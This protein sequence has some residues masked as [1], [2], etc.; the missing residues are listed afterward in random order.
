MGERNPRRSSPE[1][2]ASQNFAPPHFAAKHQ[3]EDPVGPPLPP[4]TQPLEGNS[5]GLQQALPQHPPFAGLPPGLAIAGVIQSSS[6]AGPMPRPDD[7]AAYER[8]VTGLARQIA[9][10][11]ISEQNLRGGLGRYHHRLVSSSFCSR[12]YVSRPK[13]EV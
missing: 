9:D 4:T 12:A 1:C 11:A 10:M 2:Q 6:H 3:A 8:V 7:L 5:I 13:P